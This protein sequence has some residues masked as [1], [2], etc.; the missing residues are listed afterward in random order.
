VRPQH[1]S[2]LTAPLR[3]CCPLFSTALGCW[4][5]GVLVSLWS[6]LWCQTPSGARLPVSSLCLPLTI[7]CC[8]LPHDLTLLLV[9]VRRCAGDAEV[10]LRCEGCIPAGAGWFYFEVHVGA[11]PALSRVPL[12]HDIVSHVVWLHDCPGPHTGCA[13]LLLCLHTA[14]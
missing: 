3:A 6:V 14:P 7:L 5:A 1:A 2:V 11:R 13:I 4:V 9:D 8:P 12:T 10:W